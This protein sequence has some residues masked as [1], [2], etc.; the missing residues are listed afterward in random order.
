MLF[1]SRTLGV[2]SDLPV[3]FDLTRDHP[4][5]IFVVN[6]QMVFLG[7]L[8]RLPGTQGAAVDLYSDLK[9]H[10]MGTGLAES[11]DEVGTGAATWLTKPLWGVGI[12][13]P[14]MHDGRATTLTEAILEH[15]GEA[16]IARDS[17]RKLTTQD[18]LD[19]LLFLDNLTLLKGGLPLGN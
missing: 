7:A 4:G 13:A 12:T 1:R 5:N 2:R 8:R 11:I 16:A 17:F 6:N 10:Y 15:G 3:S 9:R 19:L 14:Y 18:Q